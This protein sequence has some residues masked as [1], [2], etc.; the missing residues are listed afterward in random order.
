M[1]VRVHFWRPGAKLP[2]AFLLASEGCRQSLPFPGL[3]QHH[4]SDA[5]IFTW[6]S[7]LYVS[8][9]LFA[10]SSHCKSI[11][12]LDLGT[13]LIPSDLMSRPSIPSVY[14]QIRPHSEWGNTIHPTI[15]FYPETHAGVLGMAGCCECSLLSKSSDSDNEGLKNSLWNILTTFYTVEIIY[16]W[17]IYIF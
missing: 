12:L 5:S 16:K 3:R 14:F 11:S 4:F 2:H 9:S 7:P 10:L 17:I 15:G 13:T 1:S 8:G 6:P